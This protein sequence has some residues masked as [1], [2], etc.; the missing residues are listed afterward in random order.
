MNSWVGSQNP[1]RESGLAVSYKI[2][3]A[4]TIKSIPP[5]AIYGPPPI[6]H[7][8]RNHHGLIDVICN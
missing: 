5:E 8:E 1:I 3:D 2:A 6:D 7:P 4:P